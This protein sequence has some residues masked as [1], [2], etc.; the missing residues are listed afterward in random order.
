MRI[1]LSLPI[2]APVLLIALL[3]AVVPIGPEDGARAR[4]IGLLLM[5]GLII[6]AHTDYPILRDMAFR[7]G[8]YAVFFWSL[9]TFA[10]A[11]IIYA[12]LEWIGWFL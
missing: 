4:L 12:W 8:P 6:G 1:F 11:T 9:T 7:K 3:L 2:P 10:G 5:L